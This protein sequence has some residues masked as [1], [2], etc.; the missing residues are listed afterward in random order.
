MSDA[1]RPES[2]RISQALAPLLQPWDRGDAPGLVIG[3]ALDGAPPYQRGLGLASV[4]LGV[5]NTPA[6]RMRIGSTSKHFTALAALLLAEEGKLD[7]DRPLRTWLPELSGICG[8]PSLRQMAQ[9]SSGLRDP[10]DLP[11][12]L[13]LHGNLSTVV[14]AGAGLELA[15]RFTTLNHPAGERML[16]CNQNYHLLSLAIERAAGMPLGAFLQQRIL[17]PLGM[18]DTAL[19]PSDLQ[20][21]PG[22]AALHLPQPDGSYRRGIYPNEELLGSGG[23]ISTVADMLKWLAHLRSGDKRVGSAASWQQMLQRPRYSSG[24]PGEYCLGLIREPY[25]GTEIIHHAGAVIG[26][27]CQMLTVPEHGLDLVLMFNRLDGPAP[28][29]ALKVVDAMLGERLQPAPA[30]LRVG[31]REGLLGRWYAPASRRLFGVLEQALPEQPP[32]LVL[33]IQEQLAGPLR[34]TAGGLIMTSPAHGAVE[35]CRPAQA[36]PQTLQILDSG[37]AETY[38][39]LPDAGPPAAA[40]APELAGRYRLAD[41]DLVVTLL[42]EQDSLYLDLHPRSGFSRF[43]LTP[44]SA[45]ICGCTLVSSWPMPLPASQTGAVLS[46]ERRGGSV[47][48]LWLNSWR[49]RN[50]WLE[51]CAA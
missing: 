37:H 43:K 3:V 19:L 48:G 13:L 15:A 21:A 27:T 44:Y 32:T 6:T 7:L 39:R 46:V 11:L 47:A 10:F 36:R 38:V 8:E 23:M 17:A 45:D 24:A 40:L 51:R 12:F 33:S 31:G 20:M 34:E 49:S 18:A 29:L 5:A 26:G 14:A 16:Y 1:Q 9:H 42:L 22:L 41:L 25:R 35:L 28:A 30:P 2:L 4:E 50:L